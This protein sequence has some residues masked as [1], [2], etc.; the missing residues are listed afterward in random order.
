M[1]KEAA[2]PRRTRLAEYF[3]ANAAFWAF[4]AVLAGILW[5]TCLDPSDDAAV[6]YVLGDT[7]RFMLLLFGGGFAVVTLFDAAYEY[8]ADRAEEPGKEP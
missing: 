4:L 3:W 6:R 7:F 5:N 2:S 1:K 8:F